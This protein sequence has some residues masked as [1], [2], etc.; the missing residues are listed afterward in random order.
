MNELIKWLENKIERCDE[1]GNSM[2]REKW[3]FQQCLKE[4]RLKQLELT[5]VVQA[6]PEVCQCQPKNYNF[7][8]KWCNRCFICEEKIYAN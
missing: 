2:N 4:A 5:A 7:I 3:A 8:E 1:H 6:K